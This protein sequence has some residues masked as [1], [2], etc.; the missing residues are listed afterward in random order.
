M[1]LAADVGGTK[2]HVACFAAA[3]GRLAIAAEGRFAS[4][5]YRGL[6]ELLADFLRE[7][8]HPV[9]A[10]C[11]GVAGPVIDGRCEGVNLPWV[12]EAAELRRALRVRRV[13]LLNDL[14]ALAY[15]TQHVPPGAFAVLQ[16]GTAQAHGAMAIVAAGTG[17]GEAALVWNG[18]RY[19]AVPAE[20]GHA[21]FAPRTD[22]EIDLLRYLRARHGRVS[23]ERV[24]SGPGLLAVYEFLRETGRGREPV[25][26]RRAM[27][28]TDPS[29]VISRAGLDGRSAL[30][31]NAIELFAA[32]YGAEAGNAA[33]KYLARGGVYL[34]GGIAPRLLPVLR[35]R[36]FLRAFRA[37]GR[38]SGLMARMPVRVVLD[39]RAALYGAASEAWR[40]LTSTH[41][42]G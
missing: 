3:R 37:K 40:D 11:V 36:Q 10:A 26:L 31:R 16:R 1:I 14:E 5:S 8:R 9:R 30:C 29:P 38:L 23:C 24:L 25:W 21:D 15:G 17:L 27:R 32:L 7:S 39:E 41:G 33:L 42:E 2:T 28:G 12:V 35:G 34:G 13:R 20:G 6:P 22:V 19:Q 18:R 4:A